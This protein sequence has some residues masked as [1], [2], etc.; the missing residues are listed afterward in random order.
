[1]VRF[2]IEYATRPVKVQ[3][4][5]VQARP[6][7]A[8]F[9]ALEQAGQSIFQ[10]GSELQQQ[11]NELEF[12]EG[13]RKMAEQVNAAM[14]SLTGD[15]E[16]DTQV[17]TRLEQ[18][19]NSVQYKSNR[20][21]S[22]LQV[23][24]NRMLPEAQAALKRQHQAL[25]RQTVHDKFEAEGQTYLAKGDLLK[26]HDILERRL[27]TKD[28]TQ[29]QFD[30]MSKSAMVDSILEQS[31][32]MI[33]TG[34][35]EKN[36]AALRMLAAVP[37]MDAAT[38][39]KKEYAQKLISIA[40]RD[41]EAISDEANKQLTDMMIGGTLSTVE[42]M[43]RRT[44]LKDSDY[45]AWAKIA[46]APVD[47]P[48]NVIQTTELKTLSMDVW[49]GTLSRTDAE[50]RIRNS[51]ADPKGINEKQYADIYEDLNREVKAYQAQDMKTYSIEAARII[52]GKDAGVMSFD[53]LGNMTIDIN[54]LLSPQA[55]FEKKMHFVDLY[56]KQ[57]ADYLADN[58]KASKKEMYVK[59][60]ELK[61]TY[62][63]AAKGQKLP[64]STVPK[65]KEYPDAVWNNQYNMWTV[66]RDGRLMGVK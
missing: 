38:T 26:Y 10:I 41:N 36:Q 33:A 3:A 53:A 7:L 16:A 14:D 64:T 6:N 46:M 43:K 47:K 48:G 31:R 27:S 18:D 65:P 62:M 56:N 35:P 66:I 30:A 57:M 4:T 50:L 37:G 1:M 34:N 63:A 22:A 21:N 25:L 2:D 20:V 28:I 52:L 32:D 58:P 39:E 44:S 9:Q 15:E 59:A 11:K 23:H 45:Q 60:Q 51:L 61:S 13:Q 55:E 54:K 24:R 8:E 40:N 42:V 17:W 49:R 19:L 29:P 5:A 12:S